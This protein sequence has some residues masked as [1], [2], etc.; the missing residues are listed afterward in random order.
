MR[1][2][3]ALALAWAA[4]VH[5]QAPE[6]PRE[7][8]IERSTAPASLGLKATLTLG[9]LKRQGSQYA[10]NYQLTTSPLPLANE[11]G[12]LQVT[13]APDALHRLNTRRPI[14]FTG[15]A[16]SDGGDPRTIKG[17]ATPTRAN[18]GAIQMDI[19]SDRLKLRFATTYRLP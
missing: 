18:G 12:S 5:A 14:E 6:L 2:A 3:L 17:V 16:T 8:R 7:L 4:G 11:K 19:K 15:K 10:G 1:L 13:L 9:P